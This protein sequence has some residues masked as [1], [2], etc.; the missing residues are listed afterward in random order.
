VASAVLSKRSETQL[1]PVLR[2]EDFGAR[3]DGFTNDSLA[4]S[5]LARRI[6]AIGGGTVQLAAGRTYVVGE[7]RSRNNLAFSPEPL[8]EVQQLTRPF[9][10]LGSGARLRAATGLRF[11]AFDSNG[12]ATHRP[13]PDLDPAEVASP[14]LGMIVVRGAR[15]PV[16]IQDIEL[17]GN[18]EKLILGGRWG[19]AGY[20]I[21]GSGIALFGNLAD[22]H[23]SNIFS[24][25]H[26]LDG[27]IVDGAPQRISRSHF[28]SVRCENNG[29]Q[30]LS[31]VAGSGYDF[32]DCSFSRTGRSA[33]S[34]PPG[35]GVDIEA[36]DSNIRDITFNNCRFIDNV[37]PG[38]VADS[39]DS[40]DIHFT[41]CLF[42]GTTSWAAWPDRPLTSFDHC[43]FAGTVV[44]PFSSPRSAE[45]TKFRNCR[46]TDDPKMSPTA[47]LFVG[48][49]AGNGIV[50]MDRSDNVL[51][52]RCRF[53]LS[54]AGLLPWSW[55]AVYQNCAMRQASH[56]PAMTKGKYLG[57]TLIDGPVDLYGSMIIGTVMLNGKVIPKGPVGSDFTPW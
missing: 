24:H 21:P 13:M 18:V 37:G 33:V 3:G 26:P 36:E 27:A 44:H 29:R 4:F 51:F 55:R 20:Q 40:A 16:T 30:G 42:V 15:A 19:D 53:E 38:M 41:D 2:P 11:G 50:N 31:I 17:D 43:T 14:Y 48:G 5:L 10:I 46:F 22:E 1:E 23:V 39:G 34:S 9:T 49:K 56:T 25:H 8:L 52:D 45:A 57:R 47:R 6:M 7:Q 35:A 28:K 12:R 32:E 54:H